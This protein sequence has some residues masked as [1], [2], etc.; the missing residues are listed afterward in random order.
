MEIMHRWPHVH[1]L[2]AMAQQAS[3]ATGTERPLADFAN[4]LAAAILKTVSPSE[5]VIYLRVFPR[6]CGLQTPLDRASP[7]PDPTLVKRSLNSAQSMRDASRFS[8]PQR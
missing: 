7:R 5:A 3:I 1:P 8:S 4:I 2:V 6:L